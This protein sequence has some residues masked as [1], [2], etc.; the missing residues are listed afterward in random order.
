[1]RKWTKWWTRTTTI[2][3]QVIPWSLADGRRQKPILL[4]F[5]DK[6]SFG[7][8]SQ[9]DFKKLPY[10]IYQLITL[11]TL[12]TNRKSGWDLFYSK[13]VKTQLQPICRKWFHF[14]IYYHL[15]KRN[16][17]RS[18]WAFLGTNPG[19]PLRKGVL[20]PSRCFPGYGAALL[21]IADL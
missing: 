19:C 18:I 17:D 3:T 5:F 15:F 11:T 14:F 8:K 10:E 20:Q 16:L 21:K 4:T 9:F 6:S 7:G 1:M 2:T 12:I 13:H